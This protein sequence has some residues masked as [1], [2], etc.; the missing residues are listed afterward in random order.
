[1]ADTYII[2]GAE[3]R[4]HA[5]CLL[6]GLNFRY[7]HDGNIIRRPQE[8]KD[9]T[10]TAACLPDPNPLTLSVATRKAVS[11]LKGKLLPLGLPHSFYLKCINARQK[12]RKSHDLRASRLFSCFSVAA[13]IQRF[14]I[15]P[16]QITVLPGNHDNLTYPGDVDCRGGLAT[17]R[18]LKDGRLIAVVFIGC[19]PPPPPSAV[20]VSS[21]LSFQGR[22]PAS[23]LAAASLSSMLSCPAVVTES[24]AGVSARNFVC[25]GKVSRL[26][27]H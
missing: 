10:D 23:P 22:L 15:C 5:L 12:S 2:S 7:Q 4:N 21:L 26:T 18:G 13:H 19:S 25:S 20:L 9:A 27:A 16:L 1:M 3:R 17:A 14:H 24:L 6:L 8:T 11:N